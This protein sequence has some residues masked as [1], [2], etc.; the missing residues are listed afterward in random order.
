MALS[1]PL[2]WLA[3]AAG[4]GGLA[5]LGVARTLDPAAVG[6]GTH[7]QLGLPPCFSLVAWGAPCPA[8]GM[9]T[10]WA[11]ATRGQWQA[12]IEA[13]AGGFLLAAI[14]LAYFPASCY[15]L[16]GG[17]SRRRGVFSFVL[18]S[19]LLASLLVATLQWAIRLG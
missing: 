17:R 11:L 1:W 14:A 12:A 16:I 3:W 5:L 9:T 7:R 10:S 6:Y 13:N 15:L 2:R 18:G 8:C 4:V 19:G